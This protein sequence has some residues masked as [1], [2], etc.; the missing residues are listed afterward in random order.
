MKS[1]RRAIDEHDELIGNPL[2]AYVVIPNE[3]AQATTVFHPNDHLKIHAK[4]IHGL[5]SAV[6]SVVWQNHYR[7][8]RLTQLEHWRDDWT[9]QSVWNRILWLLRGAR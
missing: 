5:E 7:D 8:D 9:Q 4:Q 6:Q 1:S 3:P 2:N